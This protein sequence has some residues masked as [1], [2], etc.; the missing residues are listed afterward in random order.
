M[1]LVVT[2]NL[3]AI[4]GYF[5]NEDLYV[6][7]IKKLSSPGVKFDKLKRITCT[8]YFSP[9]YQRLA[10]N[11]TEFSEKI[12]VDFSAVDNDSNNFTKSAHKFKN[13]DIT[14]ICGHLN[15]SYLTE[16]DK[17]LDTQDEMKFLESECFLVNQASSLD[18]LKVEGFGDHSHCL[19]YALK[20]FKKIKK[21]FIRMDNL[22]TTNGDNAEKFLKKHTIVLD[23]L[24]NIP[25]YDFFFDYYAEYEYLQEKLPRVSRFESKFCRVP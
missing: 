14:T 7:L 5:E 16:L 2:R 11:L 23:I 15:D 20:K 3:T 6:V 8:V 22:F 10:L 21:A 13:K 17:M 9:A 18:Y 19:E 4:D 24:K 1:D 12:Y 25:E